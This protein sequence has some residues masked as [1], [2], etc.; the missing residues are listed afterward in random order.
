MSA[1]VRNYGHVLEDRSL[2]VAALNKTAAAT[3]MPPAFGAP[4][5]LRE[6]PEEPALGAARPLTEPDSPLAIERSSG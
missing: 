6:A 1:R 2:T 3:A 5:A 4:T